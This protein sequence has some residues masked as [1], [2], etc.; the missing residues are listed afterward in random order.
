VILDVVFNHT[1]EGGEGGPTYS[2]RGID[3]CLYYLLDEQGRYL[4]FT[5]CGNT[6][7][8]NHPVVR[9]YVL[10]CLH[11][12]VAEAGVDGFRFDLASV[13]G[14]DP[15]GQIM[16]EP[17][18]VERITE[19]SLLAGTKLIAE[20][21][22]PGTHQLGRFPGGAR[23]SAWNSQYCDD[24]RRFWRGDAGMVSSL[25]T[26]LCGSEDLFAGLGP[27]HSLN[28]VTCHDGFTLFDLVSHSHKHNEA[29]GEGNRDGI[30]ENLSWNCGVEGSTDDLEIVAL[31]RRQARNLVA[32]LLISQGVPMLLGGDEFLRTQTGNNNAWCQDNKTSWID[33]TLAEKNL[34]VVQFVRRMIALRKRHPALRRRTFFQ[35]GAGGQPPDIVWH[36]V[37][38][39]RP[40][41][42]PESHS[43]AFV[44]DG[45][46]VDHPRTAD[47]DL[48][49]AM[50]AWKEPLSFTIPASPSGRRWCR[51][52]DTA[53]SSPEDA[54]GPDEGPVIP[55]LQPYR[56]EAHS[57]IILVSEA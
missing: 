38:P 4:N 14:R 20:P 45:R 23:W 39:C 8:S 12:W 13:L 7:N 41:F 46:R 25:A 11:N 3:N 47:R 21:W 33:W 43:L 18:V 44:L 49:V 16:V 22:D 48:Y 24:V 17:P 30:D 19:D 15:R 37:E 2:F 29:N 42:S 34:D 56:V 51:A 5:G 50:S 27:L 54:L 6:L 32:T 26:R 31:R 35:G 52:V 53:L 55:V 40:D 1:A 9:N 28:F 57:L 10:N 36:G